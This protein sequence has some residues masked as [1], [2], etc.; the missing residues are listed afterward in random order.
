MD[1]KPDL[2]QHPKL[3]TVFGGSGFVGRHVVE[4]LTKRGY[5]VRVA[6]RRP[7]QAYYISQLG[8]VGQIQMLK[9]NVRI[10]QSV[11]RALI[12]ADAAIFLPGVMHNIGKNTFD[13]VQVLGA[14]NVAELTKSAGIPLIHMS[15]LTGNAPQSI[16]YV[17]TKLAGEKAV[18]DAH[19]DAIIVRPSVIFGPEDNFFNKFADMS[20]FS[21]FLPIFGSGS[22]KMQPVYVGDVAEMI[23][24]AVDGNVASGKIYELGGPEVLT[25]RQIMQETLHIIRRKRLLLPIPYS[26]GMLMAGVFS[27]LGKLPLMPTIATPSQIKMLKFDNVVS[28]EAITQKRTLTGVGIQPRAIDAILTSYLWRFRIHGQFAKVNVR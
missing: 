13:N 15:A 2:Y 20:R 14:K 5:R 21:F 23:A 26:V 27:V 10:R 17:R 8:E 16:S 1:L 22:N 4:A 18:M 19:R 24:R 12:D 7:E 3:I 28:E 25:F 6:V 9:T 11:A